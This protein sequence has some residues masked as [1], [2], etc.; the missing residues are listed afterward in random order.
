MSTKCWRYALF[1]PLLVVSGCSSGDS[2]LPTTPKPPAVSDTSENVE[3]QSTA[4]KF[5]FSEDGE[6]LIAVSNGEKRQIAGEEERKI[7]VWNLETN[8]TG[9]PED[10]DSPQAQLF[11]EMGTHTRTIT[12]TVPEAQQYFNQGLTWMYAFNH[13]EAIR[14]SG[15]LNSMTTVPWHGGVCRLPPGLNTTTRS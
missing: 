12:T 14:S 13:D 7:R 10:L 11:D 5:T 6:R 3:K 4:E 8:S 15:P 1:A 9:T 2:E